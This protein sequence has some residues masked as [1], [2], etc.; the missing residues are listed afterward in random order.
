MALTPRKIEPKTPESVFGFLA[1][2]LSKG[3]L[4][5]V[6]AV[7]FGLALIEVYR[8]LG[9]RNDTFIDLL[10]ENVR[11]SRAVADALERMNETLENQSK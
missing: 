4:G 2:L 5:A 3:G 9:R 8:D 11:E 6:V 1:L 10:R 7:V